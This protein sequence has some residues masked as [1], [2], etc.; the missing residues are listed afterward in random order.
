MV[1]N[2]VVLFSTGCFQHH[3]PLLLT[4]YFPHRWWIYP[5]YTLYMYSY[6]QYCVSFQE[7][8]AQISYLPSQFTSLYTYTR[9]HYPSIRPVDAGGGQ[10]GSAPHIIFRFTTLPSSHLSSFQ[11]FGR[12]LIAPLTFFSDIPPTASSHL[13]SFQPLVAPP[14]WPPT[15]SKYT[16]PSLAPLIQFSGLLLALPPFP[17]YITP[18]FP[19]T[20]PVFWPLVDPPPP[21]TFF[22]NIPLPLPSPHLSSF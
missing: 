10:G 17:K 8:G 13:S 6:L 1:Y 19:L 3:D 2:K 7:L 11:A 16:T 15:F 12:P 9:Y 14:P 21:T 20:Y 22:L 18:P 5:I 4:A